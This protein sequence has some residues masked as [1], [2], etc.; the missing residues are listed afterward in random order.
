METG[1]VAGFKQM[2]QFMNYHMFYT[3][4]RQKQNIG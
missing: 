2:A 4:F 3:P 1:I